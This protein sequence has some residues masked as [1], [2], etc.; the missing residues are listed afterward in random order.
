LLNS[1]QRKGASSG[2]ALIHNKWYVEGVPELLW[3]P[4]QSINGYAL[5]VIDEFGVTWLLGWKEETQELVLFAAQAMDGQSSATD[6][7]D[8]YRERVEHP[9]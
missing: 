6:I 8:A 4:K 1:A 2:F 7:I 3:H 9:R 5:T